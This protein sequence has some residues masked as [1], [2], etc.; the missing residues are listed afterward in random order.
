MGTQS[1]S[2]PSRIV[3]SVFPA[4]ALVLCL[5]RAAAQSPN[6][7]LLLPASVAYDAAGNL[8]FVETGN[9]VVRRLTPAGVLTVVAGTGTQ[10]YAGDSGPATAARLDSPAAVAL[11]GSGNLFVAD[12]HNRCIRRVDAVT[13]IISTYAAARLPVAL[14]FNAQ[15][16]LVYADA[17]LHQV[18]SVDAATGHGSAIAGNGTQG[19]SGDGG[20]AAAAMLDTPSGLAFD[21]AGDLWIADAHNHRVRRVDAATGIITTVAGTGQPGFSGDRASATAARL[22]LP[23][24]LSVDASGNLFIADSRNQRI[25]R[26]DAST[27]VVSTIVGDG[28]QG[29]SGDGSAATSAS[30]NTPRAVTISASAL[31]TLADVANNRVRQVDASENVQTVAGSGAISPARAASTTTLTEPSASALAAGVS[32]S[33]A[34]PAGTVTLIDGTTPIASTGLAGGAASF[35][36]S[37]LSTGSHTLTAAYSGSTAL[38]PSI[39]QPLIVTIGNPAAADFTL[40]ASAP[41]SAT[42]PAGSAA[43][44]GFTIALTGAALTSPIELAASGAPAGAVA[45]FSPAV[46]PPPSGATS[47]SLTIETPESARLERPG[48]GELLAEMALAVLLLPVARRFRRGVWTA[49]LLLLIGCGERVNTGNSDL[50]APVSYNVVVSATATNPTGAALLHTASVTLVVD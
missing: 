5:S 46:I 29:F 21:S 20:A 12:A 34:T 40:T 25:R 24:G 9:H 15:G 26:V 45:S 8:Y 35:A 31:V 14:A 41:T 19:F 1:N 23:R 38:L 2:T 32:A 37:L 11:D 48:G 39:S 16:A 6:A 49:G 7:P 50:P 44:F 28:A 10:G 36:M 3:W 30:L 42:V 4:L 43:T 33:G 22:D 47:F 13:G 17:A 27:G 18:L